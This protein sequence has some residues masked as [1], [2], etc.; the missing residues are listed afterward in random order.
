MSP[1]DGPEGIARLVFEGTQLRDHM[2][3]LDGARSAPALSAALAPF[4]DGARP[5]GEAPT[6]LRLAFQAAYAEVSAQ[7][8]KQTL[9]E[10]LRGN[11]PHARNAP[12]FASF[13]LAAIGLMLV[14]LAFHFTLWSSQ[15]ES[16]LTE[17]RSHEEFDHQTH[18]M[19][20][21]ELLDVIRAERAAAGASGAGE[22]SPT[23]PTGTPQQTHLIYFRGIDVLSQHYSGE[24]D[25]PGAVSAQEGS[26]N[27]VMQAWV[28]HRRRTCTRLRT[29][30][31]PLQKVALSP[32][33]V[34][35]ADGALAPGP[36]GVNGAP[37]ADA[38]LVATEDQGTIG[39]ALDDAGRAT[40]DGSGG[41]VTRDA[42]ATT[43]LGP[44]VAAAGTTYLAVAVSGEMDRL[45]EAE[46]RA[47]PGQSAA[48]LARMR[49]LELEARATA[50]GLPETPAAATGPLRQIAT[51]KSSTYRSVSDRIGSVSADAG[52]VQ[53]Y[54]PGT[55]VM[56]HM[57]DRLAA[58]LEV[59]HRWFLPAIYGALGS[60]VYCL[61]RILSPDLSA[62]GI[63]YTLLRTSFAGLAAI[64]LSM[65]LIPS[66]TLTL[67]AEPSR[68]IIYLLCFVSGYSI[69]AFIT[70][71]SRL[72]GMLTS[73]LSPADD[74]APRA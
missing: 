35:E 36:N 28:D 55:R 3:Y 66:Q 34:A 39:K 26:L 16:I 71:L 15:S 7:V 58:H 51:E 57:R 68:P 20:L 64:T 9:R 37:E 2:V 27:P 10:V 11:P 29:Q 65:L 6:A 67:G 30:I 25:L 50:A 33:A 62:L 22:A 63:G 56:R 74:V 44:S 13:V 40:A 59:V 31:D 46:R 45:I 43:P 52:L 8:D 4:E 70:A 53:D 5:G 48:R 41:Q 1:P 61:W 18:A 72:N 19:E 17:M 23:D 54:I 14:G 60:V 21:A 49:R 32:L 47:C 73:R 38:L 42:S 69:E 24:V 12:I